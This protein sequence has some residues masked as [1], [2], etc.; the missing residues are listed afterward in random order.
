YFFTQW[1]PASYRG[2]M[3]NMFFASIA[4]CGIIGGPI[5]G[6]ILKLLDGVY[7]MPSW[8]WLFLI[9]GI[10]SIIL[11]FVALF[12]F[13]DRIE[14]AK[15]RSQ[16]EKVVLANEIGNEPKLYNTPSLSVAMNRPVIYLFSLT[17]LRL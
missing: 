8:Q 11:G 14:D 4:L 13:N 1:F 6:G 7:G 12:A 3:N 15:W 2:R 10:R 16:K 9:E 17:Y 5:S